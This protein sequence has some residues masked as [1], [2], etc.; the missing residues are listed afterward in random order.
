MII[1]FD[2]D[3]KFG[4]RSIAINYRER[5]P[6]AVGPDFYVSLPAHASTYGAKAVAVPG[7]GPAPGTRAR[8][9]SA[10]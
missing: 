8:R 7:A 9:F 3:P 1:R 2:G 6:A 5:A 10:K 4:T